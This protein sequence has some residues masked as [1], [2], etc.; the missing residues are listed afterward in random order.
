MLT[1]KTP[2]GIIELTNKILGGVKM[3][4]LVIIVVIIIIIMKKMGTKEEERESMTRHCGKDFAD[5]LYFRDIATKQVRQ[6]DKENGMFFRGAKDRLWRIEERAAQLRE[7]EEK[8]V[9]KNK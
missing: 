4:T 3:F 9:N 8:E 6:E 2:H 7:A 5:D 1:S